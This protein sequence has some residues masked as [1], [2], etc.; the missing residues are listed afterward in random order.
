VVGVK[1]ST[2]RW[3]RVGWL[4]TG[5]GGRTPTTIFTKMRDAMEI[6]DLVRNKTTNE[7]GIVQWNHNQSS[8][9]HRK[10]G[11]TGVAVLLTKTGKTVW[12]KPNEIEV[13]SA[14]K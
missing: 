6:D 8:W 7:L 5:Q 9:W 13:I 10:K 14:C 3:R 4:P 2:C 11:L 12:W 1:P